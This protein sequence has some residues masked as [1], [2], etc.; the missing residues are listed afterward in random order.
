MYNTLRDDAIC[1]MVHGC[2]PLVSRREEVEGRPTFRA[3]R[4]KV[5]TDMMDEMLFGK[6][7][8]EMVVKRSMF[9]KTL[10]PT[11]VKSGEGRWRLGK[12]SMPD[13]GNVVRD[14]ICV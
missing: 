2:S 3:R 6:R 8:V 12:R 9:E 11:W 4:R 5:S 10:C 1:S 7:I 14:D 13:L